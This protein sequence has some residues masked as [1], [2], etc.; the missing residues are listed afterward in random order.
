MFH[1]L[2]KN[3]PCSEKHKNTEKWLQVAISRRMKK[4]SKSAPDPTADPCCQ[5]WQACS[6]CLS[7]PQGITLGSQHP[8]VYCLSHT[9]NP[10]MFGADMNLH[11]LAQPL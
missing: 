9:F 1:H 8:A 4:L 7:G 2:L 10:C 3:K 11:H 5:L 6:L